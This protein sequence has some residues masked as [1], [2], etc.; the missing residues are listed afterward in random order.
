LKVLGLTGGVGMGKSAAE[1]FLRQQGLPVVDTD[2]LARQ[3]VEPGQPALDEIRAAFGDA[4][5]AAD[6]RL[7]RDELARIVFNDDAARVRLESIL[8]PRIRALWQQQVQTW[9][10]EAKTTAVVV[11]PL[12]FETGAEKELDETICI[13]CSAATQRERL[14]ARGWSET[15]IQQRIAAQLSIEKKVEKA[16]YVIWSEGNLDVMAA[17]LSLLLW[18]SD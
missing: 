2:V 13:A 16:D 7:R 17:Q 18:P 12:L 3:L 14:L 4:V 15:Q 6:G 8:H 5:L 11:I 1:S 9:C 10:G